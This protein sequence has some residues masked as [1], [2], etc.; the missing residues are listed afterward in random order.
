MERELTIESDEAYDLAHD[1]AHRLDVTPAQAVKL[2]LREYRSTL[3]PIPAAEDK[4][5]FIARVLA[6]AA[7]ARAQLGDRATSDHDDLY[8]DDGLPR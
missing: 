7:K 5:E 6:L 1:L 4:A 2:A 8:D 3:A